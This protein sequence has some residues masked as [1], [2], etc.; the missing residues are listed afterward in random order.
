[1]I[2]KNILYIILLIIAVW[3]IYRIIYLKIKKSKCDKA[4][5]SVFSI[6]KITKPEIVT[7]FQYSWPTVGVIFNCKEDY[8]FAEKL[9]LFK[10]F[11]EKVQ[12]IYK[13]YED[14]NAEQAVYFKYK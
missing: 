2:L 5:R 13:D 3:L 8:E 14:F 9:E 12:A 11:K 4:C 6:D 7:G 10:L 1:M